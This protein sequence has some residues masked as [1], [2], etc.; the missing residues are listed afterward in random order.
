MG[1]FADQ[2]QIGGLDREKLLLEVE[3]ELRGLDAAFP[4]RERN[5]VHCLELLETTQDKGG[6][7]RGLA[8]EVGAAQM[9]LADRV[10]AGEE[11]ESFAEARNAELPFGERVGGTNVIPGLAADTHRRDRVR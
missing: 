6:R 3:D 1:P 7:G 2:A 10:G 11:R 9:K 8:A 5:A 4:L